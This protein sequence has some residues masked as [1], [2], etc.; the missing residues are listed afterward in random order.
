MNE[1]KALLEALQ[2]EFI[3][4]AQNADDAGATNFGVHDIQNSIIVSNNGRPF[5]PSD[6][7]ALCR[8]GASN[9]YR[10]GN[11]IGYRGIGFK[12]VVNLAKTKSVISG[13]YAFYFDKDI[14]KR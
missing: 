13:D 5:S 10:G 6:V 14:T 11:S 9:K 1:S 3:Q 2:K 8:S 7:E 4:E 12:S